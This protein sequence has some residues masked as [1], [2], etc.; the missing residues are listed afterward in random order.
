MK[1]FKTDFDKIT[2]KNLNLYVDYPSQQY[3]QRSWVYHTS[4]NQYMQVKKYDEARKLYVLKPKPKETPEGLKKE[5]ST[6]DVEA[7]H[8]EV[9]EQITVEFR[10]LTDQRQ[11]SGFLTVNINDKIMAMRD[12]LT[13]PKANSLNILYK[14]ELVKADETF[15]KRQILK[16]ETFFMI[17][18]SVQGKKWKRFPKYELN[19]YFY[20]RLLYWDAICLIPKCDITMVGFG[21]MNQYEKQTFKLTF[22]I[23][24]GST[25]YPEKQMELTQAMLEEEEKTM[26]MIDFTEVDYETIDVKAGE[27]IHIMVKASREGQYEVR[28][29]YG[30]DGYHPENIEGQEHDFDV[31][32]SDHY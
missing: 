24:V 16:G 13:I 27:K 10:V 8:D 1:D 29:T 20:L 25:D 14:G 9:A 32:H 3:Q 21:L 19:S 28:F 6:G 17:S 12:L 5:L 18:G 26:F 23:K 7:A 30:Y 15:L 31:E 22:K 4:M 11:L 2:T